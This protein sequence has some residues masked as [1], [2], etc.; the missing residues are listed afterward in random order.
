QPVIGHLVGTYSIPGITQSFPAFRIGDPPSSW[1]ATGIEVILPWEEELESVPLLN[2]EYHS[3]G[4]IPV[5][6]IGHGQA[7]I[8]PLLRRL[9][10][11]WPHA[12]TRYVPADEESGV[13]SQA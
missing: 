13:L 12:T 5:R 8:N 11:R 10:R 4:D 7:Q 2:S 6:V 1:K 3:V 9:Q